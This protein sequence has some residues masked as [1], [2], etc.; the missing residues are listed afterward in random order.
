MAVTGTAQLQAVQLGVPMPYQGLPDGFVTGEVV[1]AG[2]GSGGSNVGVLAVED[3]GESLIR[4]NHLGIENSGPVAATAGVQTKMELM[5]PTPLYVQTTLEI[6]RGGD[7]AL[8]ALET[9]YFE[10]PEGIWFLTGDSKDIIRG[11]IGNAGVTTTLVVTLFGV[12]W[13]MTRLRMHGPKDW[14]SGTGVV[15]GSLG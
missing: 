3:L 6:G 1:V 2:D 14:R 11:T 9:R 7:G 5:G 15:L 13:R 4:I 12:F 10:Y 8:A